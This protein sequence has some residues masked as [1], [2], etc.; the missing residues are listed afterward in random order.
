MS[1]GLFRNGI[2]TYLAEH[3]AELNYITGTII[4]DLTNKLRTS[5]EVVQLSATAIK[6]ITIGW[7]YLDGIYDFMLGVKQLLDEKDYRQLQNKIKAFVNI[8][9]G[10]QLYIFSYNPPLS[11]T[12]GDSTGTGFA[13][14]SFALA[15]LCDLITA[16]IDFHYILKDDLFLGWLEERVKEYNFALSKGYD[17]QQLIKNVR[18]RIKVYVHG[19]L[20]KEASVR[21]IINSNVPAGAPEVPDPFT[22]NLQEC[23]KK[24]LERTHRIQGD[25]D[26]IYTRDR[27]Y[28]IVKAVSLVGMTLLSVAHFTSPSAEV[29]NPV[30]VLGLA[31]TTLAAAFYMLNNSEK[32]IDTIGA[33]SFR[34]F[35]CVQ[36]R[37]TNVQPI[38]NINT[39]D[40]VAL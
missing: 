26:V 25:L 19:D 33:L 24:H 29:F 8:F 34:F 9:C 11:N 22:A 3:G 36:T 13:S 38:Q 21:Q 32:L 10:I 35:S 5:T 15:T 27:T 30:L 17:T 28:L 37:V 12:I 6:G 39:E 40:A 4:N 18:A 23:S 31:T 14:P 7:N 1:F 2:Y 20:N 16:S